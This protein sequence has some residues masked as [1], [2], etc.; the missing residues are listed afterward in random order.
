MTDSLVEYTRS[1]GE[2]S[3]VVAFSVGA[4][5]VSV[6]DANHAGMEALFMKIKQKMQSHGFEGEMLMPDGAISLKSC[7]SIYPDE[8]NDILSLTEGV[9]SSYS[10]L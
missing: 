1:A 7:A 9:L 6:P 8:G 10:M 4:V 3:N 5:M 2:V